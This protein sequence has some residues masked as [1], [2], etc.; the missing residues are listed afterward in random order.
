M[1]PSFY[2]TAFAKID[3]KAFIVGFCFSSLPYKLSANT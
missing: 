1:Y 3:E 2:N